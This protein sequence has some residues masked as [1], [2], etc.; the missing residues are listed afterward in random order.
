MGLPGAD[1][2]LVGGPLLRRRG[3]VVR[4]AVRDDRRRAVVPVHAR[5]RPREPPDAGFPPF[6]G[7]GRAAGT[8][9]PPSPWL[10]DGQAAVRPTARPPARMDG[11]VRRALLALFAFGSVGTGT[12]LLLLGHTEKL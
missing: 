2:A 1:R 7:R 3:T 6:A 12:E 5:I 9:R 11:R 10:R 8:A 4:D